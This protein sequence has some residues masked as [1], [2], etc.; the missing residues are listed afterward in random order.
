MS[1]L[2]KIAGPRVLLGV[3]LAAVTAIALMWWRIDSATDDA[4]RAEQAWAQLRDAL[5]ASEAQASVARKELARLQLALV[6]RDEAIRSARDKADDFGRSLERLR[7][8]S[9]EVRVWSDAAVPAGVLAGLR[10][11]AG[12]TDAGDKA[13]AAIGA[14]A[15]VPGSSDGR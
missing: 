12:D 3:V 2:A 7:Q 11:G 6:E 8:D 14:D 13:D 1:I 5:Q 9:A 4:A 10:S 15:A